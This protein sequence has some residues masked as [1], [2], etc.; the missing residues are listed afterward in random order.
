MFRSN[1]W[2]HEKEIYLVTDLSNRGDQVKNELLKHAL[3]EKNV[4]SIL[5]Q[6]DTDTTIV[7]QPDV[8]LEPD[9][10]AVKQKIN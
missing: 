5:A 4:S 8:A 1:K 9:T 10:N 3:V 6:L 2:N 7:A